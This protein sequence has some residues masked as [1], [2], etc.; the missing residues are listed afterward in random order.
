M[1]STHLKN[2]SQIGSFPQVGMKI[3]NIWNHHLDDKHRRSQ[4]RGT[5]L[6]QRLVWVVVECRESRDSRGSEGVGPVI[7]L[8]AGIHT[9]LRRLLS[10]GDKPN[11]P[12]MYQCKLL[13]AEVVQQNQIAR[14]QMRH[15]QSCKNMQIC[16]FKRGSFGMTH[17]LIP[18]RVYLCAFALE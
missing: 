14:N 18:W 13:N 17:M 7:E 9:V 6:P 3:K 1:V 12:L 4:K 8:S 16:Q 10:V 15:P 2:I 5:P 11:C